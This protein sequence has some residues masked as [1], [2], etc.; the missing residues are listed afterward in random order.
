MKLSIPLLLHCMLQL[1][2]SLN[3][4]QV[5]DSDNEN[6]TCSSWD[7]A[8]QLVSPLIELYNPS[9]G[10]WK[11][12]IWWTSANHLTAL[13]DYIRKSPDGTFSRYQDLIE[14]TFLKCQEFSMIHNHGDM[15]TL[16]RLRETHPAPA[17]PMGFINEY[18][19]DDGWWALCWLKLYDITRDVRYL[20]AA[21]FIFE[22][23]TTGWS[24][25]C[26]GGVP[27]TLSTSYKNAISNELF[28][29][30]AASLATRIP[31]NSTYLEW[32]D[33]EWEWFSHTK[34]WNDRG[35]I[36]DGLTSECENNN[37]VVWSYNQGVLLGGLVELSKIKNDSGLMSVAYNLAD[38]AIKELSVNNIMHDVCEPDCN[39]DGL[40]KGVF[41][42]NLA[43]LNE[44]NPE[45]NYTKFLQTNA[46]SL[47]NNNRNENNEVGTVWSGPLQF[48]SEVSQSAGLDCLNAV[49][50]CSISNTIL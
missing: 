42:R 49:I 3:F 9:T 36:N 38:S 50:N 23:M 25:I 28:L 45:H 22:H 26:G 11:D 44:A 46:D 27:W 40:F 33:K 30:V 24:D 10:M 7:R 41:I 37:E 18:Y 47:W 1:A 35:T 20:N 14:N 16:E 43:E 5:I 31:D 29:Q 4:S 21:Q 32:A 15:H 8:T 2:W 39:N 13:A 19:D 17:V 48:F 12:T 34:M 6:K